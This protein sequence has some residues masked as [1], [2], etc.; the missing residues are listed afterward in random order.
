MESME[1]MEIDVLQIG[2][3]K[4]ELK[5]KLLLLIN[6]LKKLKIYFEK[7]RKKILKQIISLYNII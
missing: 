4:I 1:S 7:I 5:K 3:M 2:L 6:I